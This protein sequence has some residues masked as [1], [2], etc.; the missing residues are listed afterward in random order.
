MDIRRHYDLGPCPFCGNEEEGGI[1][2]FYITN[3]VRK[4]VTNIQVGC[5]LCD[6]RGPSFVALQS[7]NEEEAEKRAVESWNKVSYAPVLR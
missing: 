4:T 3:G 6:A 1:R 7:S 2:L 5:L